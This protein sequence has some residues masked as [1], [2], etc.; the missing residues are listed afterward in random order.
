M[1]DRETKLIVVGAPSDRTAIAGAARHLGGVPTGAE[2]AALRVPSR[3]RDLLRIDVF[4]VSDDGD[5]KHL[6]D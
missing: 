2:A 4:V 5:V 1:T 6:A 3:V